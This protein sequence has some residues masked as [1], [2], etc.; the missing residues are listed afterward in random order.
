MI[1]GVLIHPLTQI[2]DERGKV[3]HMMKATDPHFERF[4]E[5]YF[6]CVYPGVVKGWHLH[7][8]MTIHYAVVVGVIKLVLFDDRPQSPT[9]G[10]IEELFLGESN[11]C[12]VKVPPLIWNGFKGMGTKT[13]IV[14]N[15]AD[16]PHD[17]AEIERLD[18]Q[19]SRIPYDWRLKDR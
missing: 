3:M 13:A 19:S 15:C 12:L 16:I 5:I 11:Y 6:S 2:P 4:G 7:S 10:K 8:R 9:R 14:A 1:E 18:P 17:P